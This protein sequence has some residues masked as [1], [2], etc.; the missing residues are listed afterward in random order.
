MSAACWY[1]V[2][3]DLDKFQNESQETFRLEPGNPELHLGLANF[4][5]EALW[6][7]RVERE[8]FLQGSLR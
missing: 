5:G 7:A 2:L 4:Y 1:G 8:F 3:G 6:T